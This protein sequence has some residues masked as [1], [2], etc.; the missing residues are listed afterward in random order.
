[1]FQT[2]IPP[3]SSSL[4]VLAEKPQTNL[5]EV[6]KSFLAHELH[7]IVEPFHTTHV[8][9]IIFPSSPAHARSLYGRAPNLLGTW[10][11]WIEHDIIGSESEENSRKVYHRTFFRNKLRLLHEADYT[12]SSKM[13]VSQHWAYPFPI[14][15]RTFSEKGCNFRFFG[16]P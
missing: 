4:A 13:G 9:A 8:L 11:S 6:S 5:E 12:I 1:M 2:T 3:S 14:F 10:T 16:R 15:G 7:H